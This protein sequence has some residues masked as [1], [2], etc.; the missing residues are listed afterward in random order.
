VNLKLGSTLN[1]ISLALTLSLSITTAYAETNTQ[2]GDFNENTQNST[3]DSNNTSTAVTSTQVGS[4]LGNTPS[5]IA[6]T[7]M[8]SGGDTCLIG[9]S[10]AV[11]TGVFAISTGDYDR[12]LQCE[13]RKNAKLLSDLGMKIASVAL[14]CTEPMIWKAMFFAGTPCPVTINNKTYIGAKAYLYY[15]MFP[16]RLIPRYKREEYDFYLGIG[17][18]ARDE[19]EDTSSS[20]TSGI[21]HLRSSRRTE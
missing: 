16:N 20:G 8:S 13:M 9:K 18:Y 14:V 12:D 3:I 19:Q 17:E 7:Y 4:K 5:A 10:G 21:M 2:T 6:P 15:K 11:S 1:N